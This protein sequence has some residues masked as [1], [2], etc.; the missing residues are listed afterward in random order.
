[1]KK[2]RHKSK[3]PYLMRGWVKRNGKWQMAASLNRLLPP[4]SDE[5]KLIPKESSF[6]EDEPVLVIIAPWS[7]FQRNCG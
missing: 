6:L 1:M 2:K 3:E 7:F 4:C 5:I